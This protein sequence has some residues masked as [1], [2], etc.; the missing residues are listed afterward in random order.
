MENKND[1]FRIL[2]IVV[3]VFN[4]QETLKEVIER[5][6]AVQLPL[7][8]EIIII[9]DCSSDATKEVMEQELQHINAVKLYHPQNLGKGA[10]LRT[11]LRAATGDIILIQDADLE[12]DPVDY[13]KLLQPILAG[14]ADVVYGSRF[15]GSEAHR[16]LY[17]WHMLGNK[18][19]TLLSNMVTNLNLTDMETCYKV[20]R[21]EVI[22]KLSLQEN[23]FGFEP[24][25]T[26]KVSRLGCRIYEVGISYSGR[27]YNEGKKIGWRDGL[28]ALRCIIKYSLLERKSKAE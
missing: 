7:E 8:K 20:F 24:E 1:T 5:I 4:E 22:D 25:V 13:P 28:S 26:A 19:L 16:V 2:S 15:V 10:A 21:K 6:Q 17:F 11:G 23:R 27:T 9:D 14:K 12:Y 18:M 3:P